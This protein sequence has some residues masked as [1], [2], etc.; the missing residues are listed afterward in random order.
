MWII[1]DGPGNSVYIDHNG[2]S[3]STTYN[4]KYILQTTT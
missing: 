4:I 1:M 3:V 2:N